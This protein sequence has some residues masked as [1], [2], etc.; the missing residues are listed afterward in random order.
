MK[1]FPTETILELK[2]KDD[3]GKLKNVPDRGK[4][5]D[6]EYLLENTFLAF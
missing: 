3:Q 6:Y 5:T 2:Q 1:G 4:I